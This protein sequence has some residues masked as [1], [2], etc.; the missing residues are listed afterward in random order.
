VAP[1]GKLDPSLATSFP[2]EGQQQEQQDVFRLSQSGDRQ[3]SAGSRGHPNNCAPA[4]KFVNGAKGC[5]DGEK[6]ARC[7]LCKWKKTRAKVEKKEESTS[8]RSPTE[9]YHIGDA[10]DARPSSSMIAMPSFATSGGDQQTSMFV[11]HQPFMGARGAQTLPPGL[12]PHLQSRRDSTTSEPERGRINSLWGCGSVCSNMERLA[13]EADTPAFITLQDTIEFHTPS[14]LGF[15]DECSATYPMYTSL[16]QLDGPLS[17]A[18]LTD[19]RFKKKNTFLHC[20]T[21]S[22]LSAKNRVGV[23]SVSDPGVFAPS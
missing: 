20:D 8:Q 5:K 15:E 9:H 1:P 18:R 7:H 23:C 4:C 12:S 3:P 16:A 19:P 21:S 2:R 17:P 11:N 22:V 14:N 13:T 10:E 6:C